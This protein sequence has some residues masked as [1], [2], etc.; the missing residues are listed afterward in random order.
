MSTRLAKSALAAALGVSALAVAAALTACADADDSFEP[1][2]DGGPSVVP[3]DDAGDA[4]DRDSD[5][6]SEAGTCSPGGW[7]HTAL[8]DNAMLTGVWGDGAGVVWAVSKQGQVLRWDGDAWKVHATGLGVLRAIWGSSATDIWIGSDT[9]L[10]HGEGAT[11]V[12]LAFTPV[13]VPGDPSASITSIWGTGP[14]DVWAVGA[15]TDMPP[16]SG[17]VLHYGGGDAG[18]TWTL[19]DVTAEPIAFTHVW[20]GAASG[21]WLAGV[22]F[23]DVE[24]FDEGVVLRREASGAAFAPIVMP[25]DPNDDRHRLGRVGGVSVPGETTMVL[26]AK[27]TYEVPSVWRASSPDNGQSFTWTFSPGSG[28]DFV[29]NAVLEIAPNDAWAAGEYGR[30]RH[31]NGTR[32]TQSA[33]SLTNLPLTRDF[34]AIW[35][36]P[37]KDLWVVGDGLAVKRDLSK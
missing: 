27:S 17:R 2:P 12:S 37:S 33:V 34:H 5:A 20:G 29:M 24:F 18:A 30:L 22:Y 25:G 15:R 7:C 13:T 16:Y 10:L 21:V 23:S 28:Q 26:V 6:G 1:T 9:G 36:Q 3:V 4:G 35:G 8:P 31:W 14:A 32:W 19:E 11:S